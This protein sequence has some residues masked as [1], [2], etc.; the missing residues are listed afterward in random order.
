MGS[1]L[2]ILFSLLQ[3]ILCSSLNTKDPVN[4]INISYNI[5]SGVFGKSGKVKLQFDYPLKNK[6]GLREEFDKCLMSYI[7]CHQNRTNVKKIRY[8]KEASSDWKHNFPNDRDTSIT[9]NLEGITGIN[10]EKN[11]VTNV[12]PFG[13]N[14]CNANVSK[15]CTYMNYYPISSSLN[16]TPNISLT[17]D[18]VNVSLT[19]NYINGITRNF[20]YN[21]GRYKQHAFNEYSHFNETSVIEGYTF[22]L[23]NVTSI[24]KNVYMILNY[25]MTISGNFMVEYYKKC[26]GHYFRLYKV[27]SSCYYHRFYEYHTHVDNTF[28]NANIL[29]GSC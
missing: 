29:Y 24:Y 3:I 28:V 22:P 5:S 7:I 1:I 4:E 26:E 17:L 14:T 13:C 6:L 23:V 21:L 16:V 2:I 8:V 19:V 27:P 12:L 20:R 9:F 25:V 15:K 10:S 11:T 18:K